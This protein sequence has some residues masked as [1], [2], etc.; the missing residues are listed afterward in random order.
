MAVKFADDKSY[1]V[2]EAPVYRLLKSHDLITRPAY[3][4]IKADDAFKDKT[5]APNQLWQ[6]DFTYLKVIGW[7]WFYLSTILDDYHERLN[8]VT[9]A[10]TYFGWDTAIME[11]REKIKRQIIQN[12]RLNHQNNA[13]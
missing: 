12:R 3:I 7:G 1:F 6:T 4:V 10:D 9:P 11:R 8:N 5:T 13:A 2:S